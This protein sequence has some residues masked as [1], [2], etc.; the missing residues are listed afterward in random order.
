M[1][2]I[3]HWARA[4]KQKPEN[5]PADQRLSY[6]LKQ[7]NT[8]AEIW[9]LTDEHGAVMLNSEDEDCIPVW[10]SESHAGQWATGEWQDCKPMAIDLE[11]WS[12]RWSQGLEDD[13]VSIAAFPNQEE[14]GI[15]LFP[16]EFELELKQAKR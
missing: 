15:V 11:T 10:P 3:R 16:H 5:L 13:E 12:S 14:E 4:M 6:L 1:A 7:V 9:I 2:K 8:N